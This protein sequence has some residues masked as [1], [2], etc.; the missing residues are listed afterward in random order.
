M[1]SLHFILKLLNVVRVFIFKIEINL[2][3]MLPLLKED[4]VSF[5]DGV[6]LKNNEGSSMKVFV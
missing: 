3:K 6:I 2:V 4:I 1:T 5:C